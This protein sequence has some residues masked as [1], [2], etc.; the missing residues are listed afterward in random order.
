MREQCTPG[1]FS[2]ELSLDRGRH[3]NEATSCHAT[4]G[5]GNSSPPGR[6]PDH[7]LWAGCSQGA[8]GELPRCWGNKH[9][10]QACEILPRTY[11]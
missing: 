8:G 3:G 9:R 11:S 7:L 10:S 2:P 4:A 5:R 1:P 6:V